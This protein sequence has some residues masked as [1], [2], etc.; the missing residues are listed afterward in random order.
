M[1]CGN[2]ESQK[3]IKFIKKQ[4]T[5]LTLRDRATWACQLKSWQLLND[6][7]IRLTNTDRVSVSA[8]WLTSKSIHIAATEVNCTDKLARL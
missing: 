2:T 4:E 3:N 6:Y 1:E 8:S 5:Q 7:T